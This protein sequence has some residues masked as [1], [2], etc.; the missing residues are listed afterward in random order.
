MGA[1]MGGRAKVLPRRPEERPTTALLE[2][3][4]YWQI[5]GEGVLSI[6]GWHK[7]K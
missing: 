3:Q 5:Q 1:H 4:I 6:G 7:G 2:V